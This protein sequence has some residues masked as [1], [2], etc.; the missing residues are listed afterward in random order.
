MALRGDLRCFPGL[1]YHTFQHPLDSEATAALARVPML[2][3]LAQFLSEKTVERARWSNHVANSLRV[4]D[5][6]YPSLY[7][8]YVRLAEVLDLRQLPELYI[9][10]SSEVN[11]YSAGIERYT[12]VLCSGLLDTMNEDEVLAVLAHELGHVKCDH[13]LYKTIASDLHELGFLLLDQL[14]G[15]VSLLVKLGLGMAVFD[16]F[17]KAELS[18]DRASVLATQEPET[19]QRALAKLAGSYSKA[20]EPLSLPAVIRQ[21]QD[22]EDARDSESMLAKLMRLQQFI[23]QTHPHTVVRV[24]EVDAWANSRE[25]KRIM[26]GHYRPQGMSSHVALAIPTGHACPKCTC[27]WAKGATFCGSCGTSLRDA[28]LVCGQCALPIEPDWRACPSCGRRLR[29]ESDT[30]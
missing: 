23:S 9:D 20:K 28:T 29:E 30:A 13:V 11:A 2:P 1:L 25:Y 3:K 8:Q 24:K 10:N 5:D 4:S 18:C 17:R 16:W 22:Y 15:A 12:I 26:S 14:P 7:R 6:Q 19:V 27:V 21:A